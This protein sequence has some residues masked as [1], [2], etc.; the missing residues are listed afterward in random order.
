MPFVLFCASTVICAPIPLEFEDP[1]VTTVY[2]F[3]ND[4]RKIAQILQI[5][6]KSKKTYG[7]IRPELIAACEAILFAA[8]YHGDLICP[9]L[10]DIYAPPT[11]HIVA[12]AYFNADVLCEKLEICPRK[13]GIYINEDSMCL[14]NL[15]E[16]D[17]D[18]IID[19]QKNANEIHTIKAGNGSL[20]IRILH[21][22]DIHVD[23][24]YM[25][26]T[27]TE[28][29]MFICCRENV[30]GQ[31]SAGHYGSYNCDLPVTTLQFLADHIRSLDPQPD[32]VVY[33]GDNPDHKLWEKTRESQQSSSDFIVDFL[34]ANLPNL[35]IYP[36]L[37]NHESF[38]DNFYYPP[39][40]TN[41]TVFMAGL[42]NYWVALPEDA[43]ETIRAGGYYS[44]LIRPGLR[45]LS[46]NT[47]FGYQLN[48]YTLLNDQTA[49]YFEQH[50][51]IA[52]TL[53]A[54]ARNG[55]KVIIIGHIPPGQ[56]T[57]LQ[58][59][60]DFYGQIVSQYQDIIVGQFFGHDHRDQFEVMQSSTG[61]GLAGV[62]Y[63]AP[64][65]TPFPNIN[66]SYR[67]YVMD[68]NTYEIIDYEQYHLDLSEANSLVMQNRSEEITWK[69]AYTARSEYNLEDLRASSWWKLTE[70]F[71]EDSNLFMKYWNNMLTHSL[72]HTECNSLCKH[73][74]IC[75]AR[76]ASKQQLLNC[77][78]E[79]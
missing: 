2:P 52:R 20:P 73:V 9:G 35:T 25:E 74:V 8:G 30:T 72:P 59:Y 13:L 45:L 56:V 64:S 46:I 68:P 10:I 69:L 53:E 17:D 61:R 5:G 18:D 12:E 79:I 22:T 70:N 58:T 15:L 37:G 14:D 28:C 51:W 67:I 62:V 33:T 50:R 39:T 40:Y 36:A 77:L 38:P 29:G 26:G 6:V 78:T 19:V 43:L 76:S 11:M 75:K 1:A 44:V 49:Q 24:E 32:F 7:G 27:P 16:D 3:C 23:H 47:D 60:G 63:I 66:P 65:V 42:W 71:H 41:F 21:L 57:S 34:A 55:E 4:C 54:A 48:F 31:G